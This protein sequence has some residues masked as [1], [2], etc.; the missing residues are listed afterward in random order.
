MVA[1]ALSAVLVLAACSSSSSSGSSGAGVEDGGRVAD[2]RRLR[3]G[4]VAD[5]RRPDDVRR[6]EPG[7][8]RRHGVRDREGRHDRGRGRERR[9]RAR[10]LVQPE[11]RRRHVRDAMPR[12]H[13]RRHR[14]A[15]GDR[16]GRSST[17]AASAST[18]AAVAAYRTYIETRTDQLVARTRVFT[19]AVLAGD[20]ERARS[21][22]AWAR[23]PYEAIEPVAEAFGDLDPEIDAR[24]RTT[25]PPMPGPGS[26]GWRR[27]CGST[28]RSRAWRRSP[29]SSAPTWRSSTRWSGRSSSIPRRSRTAPPNCSARS[30]SRRSPAR[31]IATRT[32]ICGT[33]SRT[34]TARRRRSSRSG[35]CSPSAIR[36]SP[37]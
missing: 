13:R 18:D 28:A 19:A 3:S 32:P 21:T 10:A 34:S 4:R 35:R 26:T 14:D 22:F 11:R 5:R 9:S 20:Q 8:R 6:H 24:V 15:D 33:S 23:E 2:R 27:R 12:R 29:R 36:P 37:R 7:C 31:R 25:C 17:G 30:R 1:G 16:R